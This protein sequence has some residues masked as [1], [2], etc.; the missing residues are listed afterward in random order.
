MGAW[1]AE[2]GHLKVLQ[3][4]RANGCP[5][6]K[7]TCSKAALKGHLEV[8][9]WARAKG[10]TG[11]KIRARLLPRM[12]TSKS[13][14]RRGH[15]AATSSPASTPASTPTNTLTMNYVKHLSLQLFLFP[16]Y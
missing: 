1:A 14:S 5:W 4:A 2:N 8:L 6:D 13:S 16:L 12:G 9:K 11:T 3:W 10:A 7:W 15:K